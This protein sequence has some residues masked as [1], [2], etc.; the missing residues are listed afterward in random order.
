MVCVYFAYDYN[1]NNNYTYQGKIYGTYWKISSKEFINQQ[2]IDEIENILTKID[3]IASNYKPNSEVNELNFYDSDKEFLLSNELYEIIKLALDVSDKTNGVYDIT[4]G[5]LV[6]NLGFGPDLFLDSKYVFEPYSL[7]FSINDKN[8]SITKHKD[9]IFDLSSVA[10]GYAVDAI[11]DY[12][13]ANNFNNY[14]ID[15]GGEIA[16]N[17]SSKNGI[18]TIGIQ[19]PQSL[20]K[21]VSFTVPNFD[22]FIGVATSGDYLNFKYIDGELVSHSID[23]RIIKSKDN[24]VLSVTVLDQKSVAR[25]DAFATAFNVMQFNESVLLS[26]SLDIK[27]KIIYVSDGLIK[28]FESKSWQNMK[29]E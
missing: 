26:E 3:L 14:L 8:K 25:A 19:D 2:Y 9:V 27:I 16:A 28:Y 6:N 29:Y 11:S 22:K 23:P 5:S 12:L 21:S 7:K 13:M 20:Q 4:V 24:N 1:Q 18:W 10:K 15:I 17:G